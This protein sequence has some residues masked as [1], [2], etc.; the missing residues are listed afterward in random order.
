MKS[1]EEKAETCIH[2]EH[3]L[4]ATCATTPRSGYPASL[5]LTLDLPGQ[6]DILNKQLGNEGILVTTK[7]FRK[8]ILRPCFARLEGVPIA[9]GH[10]LIPCLTRRGAMRLIRILG[11]I[12]ACCDRRGRR[13][14]LTN[15][16]IVFGPDLSPRRRQAILI[17]CYRNIARV[18][19]DMFWFGRDSAQRVKTWCPLDPSWKKF[20]DIPGPKVIVTAHHGNWEMAGHIVA[21]NGYPLTSVG[22][23][24]G[25]AETT[26]KL[27]QFRSRLGQQVVLS[28]GAMLPLLKTLKRGGN[29]ALLADQHLPFR[30]GGIWIDF[31][32]LRAP[33]TPS[34]AF[35]AQRTG[36]TIGVAY[37]Q[38]RPDGS[39]HG[40][41]PIIVP[42]IAGESIE[43]LTARI[44]ATSA[45]LIRRYPTQW[46][47]AYKRWRDIPP[48][49]PRARYPFYA[50][51]VD[52]CTYDPLAA[53]PELTDP[54]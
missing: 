43:A 12:G 28:D 47:F 25:T 50:S 4:E 32:G 36:A 33:M 41:P 35:F 9:L 3:R 13:Y 31:L 16:G 19:I 37:L 45:M 11:Y 24:L 52:G 5:F 53:M 7:T 49:E 34:P 46:L 15:I 38:A 44:A 27:N 42:Q 2:S 21:S 22:K 48:D 26:R 1:E 20:L 54:Q 29:I 39:Y 6:G 23:R 14:A 10:L 8:T 18:L 51:Y 40:L 30:E 17:G